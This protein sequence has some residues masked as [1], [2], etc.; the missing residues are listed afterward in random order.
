MWIH[1]YII[2]VEISMEL[3]TAFAPIDSPLCVRGNGP[4]RI[5]WPKWNIRLRWCPWGIVLGPS[6]SFP[7]ATPSSRGWA[8]FNIRIDSLSTAHTS[9][10][11]FGN[12]KSASVASEKPK[13]LQE[14]LTLLDIF[15]SP[16]VAYCWR[17]QVKYGRKVRDKPKARIFCTIYSSTSTAWCK[18]AVSPPS[19]QEEMRIAVGA[20]ELRR[21]GSVWLGNSG[22][23]FYEKYR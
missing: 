15:R 7:T 17:S 6:T 20:K 18:W 11:T 19:R 2:D 4:H 21:I 23:Q 16:T 5:N 22:R 14:L 3:I 13:P 8:G 1:E 12:M 9:P 10:P